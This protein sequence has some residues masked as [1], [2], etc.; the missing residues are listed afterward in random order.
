[1]KKAFKCLETYNSDEDPSYEPSENSEGWEK[2]GIIKSK[3]GNGRSYFIIQ[4]NGKEI[5]RNRKFL[6]PTVEQCD[7]EPIHSSS[8]VKQRKSARLAEKVK[9]C[10]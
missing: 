8:P 2:R 7:D 5:L 10:L 3:R 9:F 1:M 4:D 6:R